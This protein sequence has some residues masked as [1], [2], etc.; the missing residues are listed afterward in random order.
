MLTQTKETK[1]EESEA[2]KLLREG[3]ISLILD[4]YDDIFSDFDPRSYAEKALSDDFLSE[5]K[6]ASRDKPTEQGIELRLLV[7]HNKRNFNE[8]VKIKKRLKDHFQKH[9]KTKEKEVSARKRQGVLWL[10]IGVVL[11]TIASLIIDK[12]GQLFNVL[13]IILE[14]AGWF[15]TWTGLDKLFADMIE[16]QPEYE[17]YQKMAKIE[18]KFYSY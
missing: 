17:F 3:N 18:V 11:I 6:K 4:E 8:E 1:D 14:P 10:A 2:K 9:F 5:C 12:E 16:K 13:V 7:P 15:T